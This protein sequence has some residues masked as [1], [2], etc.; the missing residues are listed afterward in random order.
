L[1]FLLRRNIIKI[2]MPSIANKTMFMGSTGKFPFCTGVS[3][4]W[5]RPLRSAVQ[6]FVLAGNGPSEPPAGTKTPN[7]PGFLTV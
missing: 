1:V 2:K 6:K 4:V 5:L 3:G 7:V